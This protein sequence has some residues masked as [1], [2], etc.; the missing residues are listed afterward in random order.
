MNKPIYII[1][2]FLLSGC[3]SL[4]HST[5]RTLQKSLEEEPYDVI[6][7]PGY[8]YTETDS[9]WNNVHKIRV[10][11]ANYLYQK[12]YTKNII[13]SGGAVYS[14]YVESRIMKLYAEQL[15]IPSE[16]IFTEESAEHSTENVYY[17]YRLAKKKVSNISD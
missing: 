13:F 17:S 9:T 6:I 16:N 15:E 11:W 4:F 2:F 8:P 5:K 7:V 14:P 1:F 3:S 12:G 10:E